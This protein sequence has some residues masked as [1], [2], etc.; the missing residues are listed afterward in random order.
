VA[1]NLA[2]V[3]ILLSLAPIPVQLA[4][5]DGLTATIVGDSGDNELIGTSGDDVIVAK[6]GNDV[7]RGRGGNDVICGGK[8]ADTIVGGKGADRI[9]GGG[10]QDEIIGGPGKDFIIGGSGNDSLQGKKGSDT[11]RGGAGNDDI[12]GGA[13]SDAALVGGSGDDTVAGGKGSDLLSGGSDDDLL[14]GG[15]GDDDLFGGKGTDTLYGGANYDRCFD[16]ESHLSCEVETW[17]PLVIDGNGDDVVDVEV[18]GDKTAVV[19]ITAAGSSN[20]IVWSLNQDLENIDLLVNTIGSYDGGRP[21]NTGGFLDEPIR[22]L[23][24]SASSTWSVTVES[25]ALARSFGNS[26]SGSSDDVVLVT[27]SG[28]ADFEHDGSSNFIVWAY[29]ADG[30]A[31]LLINVIGEYDAPQ[32]VPGS[33]QYLDVQAD[34]AWTVDFR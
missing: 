22:F 18:P 15:S 27:S 28:I 34:G 14:R 30:D 8:G 1:V 16:G 20:F 3:M 6:G 24:V 26:I 2:T 7:V 25:I 10:G 19:R 33:T 12:A 29:E 32:V 31:D 23:D 13:G 21:V 4:K 17:A 11:I 5:C 9:F